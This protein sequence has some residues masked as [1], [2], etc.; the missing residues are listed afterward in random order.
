MLAAELIGNLVDNAIR[1]NQ[2]G[3][4]VT[5]RIARAAVGVIAEVE[6]DGPGI[7]EKERENVFM[8]FHRLDRDQWRP[9]SGL[10]LSIVRVLAHILSAKV[11]LM[12]G[13]GGKGL[14][15]RVAFGQIMISSV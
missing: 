1:Y 7:P 8:R 13:A 6:D 4:T 5:V 11:T 12:E 2:R 14:R 10:G 15:V 9:G 3:G